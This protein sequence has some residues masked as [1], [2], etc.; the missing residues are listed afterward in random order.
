MVDTSNGR[1]Q[2]DQLAESSRLG[3]LSRRA[4]LAGVAGSAAVAMTPAI[5]A[6]AAADDGLAAD[7]IKTLTRGAQIKPGRV[8]VV[9]PELAENG[10]TVALTVTV[11]SPMTA[12]DHVKAIH[13]IADK[14]PIA[15]IVTMHL[16]PRAGRA[17]VATNIRLA[18]TQVVTVLA[19][20]SDGQYWS[21]AQEVI[22]TLAACMD[23]G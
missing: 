22:V 13:V 16:G 9:M 23:A 14:N 8:T 7:A 11:D 18:T 2:P 5:S 15:R 3:R 21:G 1:A 12:A 6:P 19:E 10:N 17:K 20:M 4:V